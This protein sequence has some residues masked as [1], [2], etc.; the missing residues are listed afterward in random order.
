M[1]PARTD[2]CRLP[3]PV[4]LLQAVEEF[5]RGAFFEQHETLEAIWIAESDPVRYLY[6]GILQVG[7]GFYH[8]SRGNR[9]G[10]LAKLRQ[11]IA[12]LEPY[13]PDCQTIDVTRLIQETQ[14]LVI[15]L[16]R[17]GESDLPSFPPAGLPRIHRVR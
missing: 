8:W 15:E 7:V 10:A 5:N 6:Q 17:R 11:G 9:K 1:A 4:A 3:P 2:R 14:A 13:Q 16:E 12:K